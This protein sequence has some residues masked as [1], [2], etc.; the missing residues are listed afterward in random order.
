MMLRRFLNVF[1]PHRLEA[2]IREEIEFH[3]T[4]SSGP[5]G[6]AT[7][8]ADR[9][10]D[11]STIA[12]LETCLQDVRYGFRQLLKSPVLL[13]VAVLSLALGIGANTAIFTLINAIMLQLLPVHDPAS[14]VLFSDGISEGVTSG[15]LIGDAVSY[16]FYRDLRA[17]NDS[18][19]NLCAFRQGE[20]DVI[21]HVTGEP[22]THVG[23][24]SVH[25]VSGNYFDVLGVHAAAGRLLREADDTPTSAPVAVIGY[26]LWKNR[27]HLDPGMLGKTVVLNGTAFTVA[28]VADASF[29]GERIR[30]SPDFWLPLSFQRPIMARESPLLQAMNTYWLNCMGRLKPAVTLK[31]AQAGVNARLHSYYLAQAGTHPAA[32]ARHKIDRVHITL[33]PGGGGISGLRYNYS[34]PLRVLMAA[35]ALVLLIACANIATLLLARA[36]ARRREFICRLA[37]GAARTRLLRQVLTE[38]ILLAL[39]GGLAGTVFAWWSVKTLVLLLHF[40]PV[41]KVEPDPAVLAFTLVLSIATGILFGIIPGWKFSRLDPRP[42][43][44]APITWRARR[45]GSTQALMAVQIALSLCLLIGAGLLTHSLVTL[46]LQD[47]GFTRNHVLLIRTDADLAGYEPSQYATLYRDIGDRINQLPGIQS[48]AIARFSPV[49][50]HSSS[51]NFSI[52]GYRPPA[53]KEMDVWD[54]PV[55]ARF[56]ETLKIPLLLGRIIEAR[57]TAASAPVAVVNQTFVNEYFPGTNPL[58]QHMEHGDPFKAPGAEIV[59]VVSDSKFFNLREK[60]KPMVFYP[61]SQKTAHSFE[62]VLRTAADPNSMAAEVRSVLKQINSRLPILEQQTLNDQIEHSLEQQKMITS[63]CSIFGLLALLLASIGIYGTLAYSVASRTA[64][65]GTRMAIGAQKSHVIW[66]VLRDLVFVLLLGLPFAF[67][68]TRWLE[69]FLFGVR[70]LDPLALSASVLL[71]CAIALFAGYLPARRAAKIEPMRALRHE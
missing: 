61:I 44:A 8:I 65:I 56:F 3:R 70:P 43:N 26:G 5:F 42:G 18:F 24:A 69:S 9:M 31:A 22:E 53:G 45:F 46:E 11:A 47:V 39:I 38:S 68:A 32:D 30:K 27:F 52:Q 28:G 1:R 66:L 48:A 51:G 41:V 25:L 37:L 6:N 50:G 34:K 64:E 15:D 20:D 62:L 13:A 60:P 40:D 23:Y 19:Q 36:S 14:L 17:H 55:G 4:Q 33:K 7:L 67:G 35:V 12:W 57:D 2:D 16:P 21:M 49:S 10:R 59:G 29:F 63:L 58:G 54:L 71:I